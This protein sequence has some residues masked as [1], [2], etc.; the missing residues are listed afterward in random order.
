MFAAAAGLGAALCLSGGASAAS[1]SDAAE[2]DR[3][4]A[5]CHREIYERYRLTPMANA[6]GPALPGLM[7]AD[8]RH[9]ESGVHYRVY[10]EEGKAWLSY[11][12]DDA[13]RE[14]EG[15]QELKYFI[16]SGKRG[17]TYLFEQQGY[18]FESPIN[19]YA[20]KGAWDMAPAYQSAHEMPLTLRVDPG[21]LSCHASGAASS[22]PDAR[23][24][25][26]AE[27]FAQSGI[28]C[29]ACHGNGA[30]HVASGGRVRMID[31]NALE[32]VRRDSI[33]LQCHLEGEVAVT[34]LSRRPEAFAPGDDLFDYKVYFV[35]RR[36]AGSAERATSQ[37]EA[38]L[39][40]KC[41]EVSAHR[42]TCT[43]CH[44]PHGSPLPQDRVEFYRQKCLQCHSRP[45]FARDHH[46][47]NPDCTAC[48]M[49]RAA[50][51]DIAHQQVTDHWI[52]RRPGAALIAKSGTGELVSV[53]GEIATDREFGLAYA[54]LAVRGD[55][56]AAKRALE[57]L[58]K[59][60]ERGGASGDH[61]LHAQLGFLEQVTGH[62]VIAVDE[63]GVAL[64]AD[65]YDELAAGDL[66]LIEAQDHRY[67][68]A[69]SL[70]AGV[71]ERDPAEA[72]AGINLA[73]LECGAGDRGAAVRT[74]ERVLH[75][76][77]D[78]DRAR[79]MLDEIRTGQ[80][81]CQRRTA[82]Q[83]GVKP[84]SPPGSH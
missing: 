27:P 25:Y 24:H 82:R 34:R 80:Q 33:C 73:A 14:L 84:A 20:R 62:S 8:F 7:Q 68:E 56:D 22:L 15:R 2:P 41:K 58:R 26:A 10:E 60:E 38:L 28:T 43:T 52:R 12:R 55:H 21:C 9:S 6:S 61:E 71:L 46:A 69:A 63:Y 65:S 78:Q 48:H 74:L 49:A 19:W 66:A 5:A 17:R 51:S 42:M 50:A 13:A 45:G 31:L 4:C 79:R 16:G 67:A 53:G 75:F 76:D 1:T 64:K 30:A 32:P 23:N 18:W 11:E 37:W 36:E 40:S 44:D 81:R 77:P 47:E 35:H 29:P 57:L 59:A 3:A 39:R 72:G 54:Q 70:W 83:D